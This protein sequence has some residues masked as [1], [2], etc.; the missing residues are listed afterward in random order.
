[1]KRSI[2][3]HVITP[4]LLTGFLTNA[5]SAAENQNSASEAPLDTFGIEKLYPSKAGTVEWNS[6][7][8]A[9]GNSREITWSGDKDDPLG[10]TD[11]HS[12]GDAP[13]DFIIDGEGVMQMLPKSPRFHI[14]SLASGASLQQFYRDVEFTAY[15]RRGEASVGNGEKDYGGMVLGLRSG[16]LG[17]GSS[18]GNN[19]DASTY[20]ARI[21]HDGKWDFEKEWKHPSSYYQSMGVIGKQTP[22]WG[23]KRLEAN[24]WIGMKFVIYNL[25]E[26]SVKMEMYIDST[27]GGVPDKLPNGNPANAK[28]E[29]VGTAIDAGKDWS[30]VGRDVATV[31]GCAEYNGLTDAYAPILEGHGTALMRTDSPV[32][33]AVQAEYKFV[34][35]REI[36][37]TKK[38]DDSSKE[39]DSTQ[40]PDA[41]SAHPVQK[42]SNGLIPALPQKFDAMGRRAKSSQPVSSMRSQH[43]L[44]WDRH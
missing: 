26:T 33:N 9:N 43:L 42:F 38:F 37:P 12:D 44:L 11:N 41:I 24:R 28:W 23:G 35:I 4:V 25:D 10:Y 27:S 17:H 8:W 18:G 5:V 20:Y 32:D 3:S 16:P 21:R 22:L 40:M 14:N 6:A 39:Q 31:E 1:M 29:L 30:G 36:D 2:L 34:S 7:H 19:C 13:V 15:Y